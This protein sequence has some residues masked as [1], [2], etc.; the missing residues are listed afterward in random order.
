MSGDCPPHDPTML[1]DWETDAP[2]YVVCE[3][4]DTLWTV[5]EPIRDVPLTRRVL[6]GYEDRT[7][8]IEGGG[9]APSA[10]TPT[11]PP[12]PGGDPT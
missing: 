5:G 4:C 12:T 2:H 6:A 7:G 8:V 1:T 11:T 9:R 10:P 3:R